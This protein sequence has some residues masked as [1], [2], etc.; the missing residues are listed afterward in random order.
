MISLKVD[1]LIQNYCENF[2]SYLYK[3]RGWRR[4]MLDLAK[5]NEIE[6]YIETEKIKIRITNT[7]KIFITCS[8][9]FDILIALEYLESEMRYGRIEYLKWT[10]NVFIDTDFVS[11]IKLNGYWYLTESFKETPLGSIR[12]FE[13]T[14]ICKYKTYEDG[15]KLVKTIRDVY[16]QEKKGEEDEDYKLDKILLVTFLLWGASKLMEYL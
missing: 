13:D 5:E 4:T 2:L 12:I 16:F 9:L 7:G 8:C 6:S 14:A 15:E 1:G 3:K 11:E 10:D